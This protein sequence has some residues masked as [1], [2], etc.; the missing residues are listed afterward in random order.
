MI[1]VAASQSVRRSVRHR[2][3][4]PE[5]LAGRTKKADL[6]AVTRQVWWLP[7]HSRFETTWRYYRVVRALY[8]DQY[9]R[10]VAFGPAWF[11]HVDLSKP[12]PRFTVTSKA[13]EVP[14]EK[15]GP[16]PTR[17]VAAAFVEQLEDLFDL[18]RYHD[19]LDKTPQGQ[20]CAYFEMGKCPAPCDGTEAVDAYLRRVTQAK[21][22][23]WGDRARFVAEWSAEMSRASGELAFERAGAL[24]ARLQTVGKLAGRG[25]EHARDLRDFRYLVVQRGPGTSWAA[26]FFVV[27]GSLEEGVPVRLRELEGA[28]PRWRERLAGV[29][30]ESTASADRVLSTE[31]V[32]LV[33]HFLFKGERAPGCYLPQHELSDTTHVVERIRGA[34]APPQAR[35][36]PDVA[37]QEEGAA[38]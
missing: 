12:L 16:F 35:A 7:T 36:A 3:T 25:H 27:G 29:N 17:S 20:A 30:H 26:P 21:A 5:P 10:L 18:C 32:W 24:K 2:L 9:R 15:W 37:E 34:L 31:Q 23:A 33:S 6:A 1:Q 28:V 22:F 11:V 19:V 14:G 13:C 38:D 4:A 8:P